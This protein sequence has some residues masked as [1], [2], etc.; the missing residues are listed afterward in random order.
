V[1]AHLLH[2]LD[3]PEAADAFDRAI[4]LSADPAVRDFLLERRGR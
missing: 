3:R 4:G 2:Q 1:R